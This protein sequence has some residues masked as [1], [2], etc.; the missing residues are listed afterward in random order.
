MKIL[1]QDKFEL[2]QEIQYVTSLLET[3]TWEF[4]QELGLDEDISESD[5]LDVPLLE[6]GGGYSDSGVLD[7]AKSIWNF[8]SMKGTKIRSLGKQLEA[9]IRIRLNSLLLAKEKIN[10]TTGEI[11]ADRKTR[12][13]DIAKEKEKTASSLESSIKDKID[14]IADE[15]S[16]LEKIAS[17]AKT[18]AAIKPQK[19]KIKILNDLEYSDNTINKAKE[20]QK[21]LTAD[22]QRKNKEFQDEIKALKAKENNNEKSS[23]NEKPSSEKKTDK[24]DEPG[25]DDGNKKKIELANSVIVKNHVKMESLK[26][27]LEEVKKKLG[28]YE[29]PNSLNSNRKE[30]LEY[31]IKETSLIIIEQRIKIALYNDDREKANDLKDHYKKLEEELNKKKRV[32]NK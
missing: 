31:E 9:A 2:I 8:I 28:N 1:N 21:E 12:I 10:N 26:K 11:P 16:R 27:D 4:I 17:I 32:A 22:L 14:A 5:L 25:E 3:D 30:K 29:N 19:E 7:K 15:D 24:K 13:L 6:R 20:R 18:N 23:S